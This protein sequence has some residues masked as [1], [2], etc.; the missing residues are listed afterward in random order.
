MENVKRGRC[1]GFGLHSLTQ[2]PYP[3]NRQAKSPSHQ[4]TSQKKP[5]NHG[6]RKSFMPL[7][8]TEL[9]LSRSC[10]PFL[11]CTSGEIFLSSEKIFIHELSRPGDECQIRQHSLHVPAMRP[12]RQPQGLHGV[13]D[14]I[15]TCDALLCQL[16]IQHK[17][18][19]V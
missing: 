15:N 12:D 3:G 8:I 7:N 1:L 10:T 13:T 19:P 6:Y 16:L 4:T 5:Y 17:N 11:R 18:M 2:G 14:I 9:Q